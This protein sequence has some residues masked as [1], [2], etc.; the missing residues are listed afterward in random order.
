LAV[1]TVSS[2]LVF[3]VLDLCE[4]GVLAA[5]AKEVAE[6]IDL[7]ASGSALVEEREGLLEVGALRL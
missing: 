4:C 7:D 5:C 3:E 6:R 2:D 1:H